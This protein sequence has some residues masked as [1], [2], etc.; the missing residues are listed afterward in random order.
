[1]AT[2]TPPPVRHFVLT[3][4]GMR[5]VHCVRAVTQALAG[6]PGARRA[7]VSMGR[8]ELE[9]SAP[10]DPGTVASWLSTAGYELLS[11][12]PLRGLPQVTDPDQTP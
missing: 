8:A 7:N 4:G 10:V 2:E 9:S 1:M 3:I 11:M 12:E 6:I 5:T